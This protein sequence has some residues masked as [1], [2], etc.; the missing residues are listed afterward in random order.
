MADQN[1]PG[2][3]T[4]GPP[5]SSSANQNQVTGTPYVVPDAFKTEKSLAQYKT[6]EDLSKGHVELSKKLGT[7]VW[8]PG[9]KDDPKA[10][11]EKMGRIY[12]A[13]GKPE[14]FDKYDTSA[15]SDG[16]ALSPE[17][18]LGLQQWAHTNHLN[19]EQFK[20]AASWLTELH[21][22]A[23]A[24]QDEKNKAHEAA[25]IKEL[26]PQGYKEATN[27]AYSAVKKLGGEGLAERLAKAGFGSDPDVV[28]VFSQVG[29]MLLEDNALPANEVPGAMT[30]DEAQAKINA[31]NANPDD[32]Y[33]RKHSGKPGHKERVAEMQKWYQIVHA[34]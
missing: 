11:A 16:T 1:T 33:H 19:Q 9:E 34:K 22:A 12:T 18:L 17:T 10:R 20:A 26:G 31:V 32:L 15:Y 5:G 28:K 2:S 4:S 13:M 23:E 25:L 27:L 29:R 3:D 8:L 21:G 24:A 6:I 30:K 14:T 7:A